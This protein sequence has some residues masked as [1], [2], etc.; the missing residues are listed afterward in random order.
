[1]NLGNAKKK[2][3]KACKYLI[4]II[5]LYD[6][7]ILIISMVATKDYGYFQ[8]ATQK[9]TYI[10]IS[11]KFDRNFALSGEAHCS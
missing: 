1:M 7:N 2:N 3:R 10:C 5:V 6:G 11:H 9:Y 4:I 8:V